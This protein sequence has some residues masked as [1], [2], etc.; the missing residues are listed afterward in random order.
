MCIFFTVSFAS[1]AYFVKYRSF[2]TRCISKTFAKYLMITRRLTK[3]NRNTTTTNKKKRAEKNPNRIRLKRTYETLDCVTSDSQF[4]P[5][6]VCRSDALSK[7]WTTMLNKL[8]INFEWREKCGSSSV[9]Y[10]CALECSPRSTA[11]DTII[12]LFV[13]RTQI[14]ALGKRA[15][16]KRTRAR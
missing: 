6:S 12:V 1:E 11:G 10:N 2:V 13:A 14:G 4:Q 3:K 15:I 9:V 16:G 5:N 7:L 8:L